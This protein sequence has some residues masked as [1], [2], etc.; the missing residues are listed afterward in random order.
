[1]D[2]AHENII[3]RWSPNIE[4]QGLGSSLSVQLIGKDWKSNDEATLMRTP[5][6][7]DHQV[8]KVKDLGRN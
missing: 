4:S 7:D 8:P 5:F 3:R 2:D 6:E 1:M